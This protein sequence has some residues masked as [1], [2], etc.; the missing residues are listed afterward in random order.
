MHRCRKEWQAQQAIRAGNIERVVQVGSSH[1][2]KILWIS[3]G[4]PG[5]QRTYLL[6]SGSRPFLLDISSKKAQPVQVELQLSTRFVHRFVD[7]AGRVCIVE[8]LQYSDQEMTPLR[9]HTID[10]TTG[11]VSSQ[12]KHF[13]SGVRSLAAT[14]NPSRHWKL[15]MA[16]R[17]TIILIDAKTDTEVSR[18]VISP[19]HGALDEAEFVV[20]YLKLSQ[21]GAMLAA[22]LE[23]RRSTMSI[24]KQMYTGKGPPAVSEVHVY[25]TTTWQ[26]LL[27]IPLHA[28][29][30]VLK[31]SHMD[32]LIVDCH[33]ERADVCTHIGKCTALA[34]AQVTGNG[35]TRGTLRVLNPRKH[36]W[37]F[38][39]TPATS[40][41]WFSYD[42]SP[43]GEL[44]LQSAADLTRKTS[45]CIYDSHSMEL[46]CQCRAVCQW[47]LNG[48][49]S[50][51]APS[52][53]ATLPDGSMIKFKRG[54]GRWHATEHAAATAV[55]RA[56]YGHWQLLAQEM[57]SLGEAGVAVHPRAQP[58]IYAYLR[59]RTAFP[60]GL[61]RYEVELTDAKRRVLANWA[62]ADL[63]RQA[64]WS[65]CAATELYRPT[66]ADLPP[67][68][69]TPDGKGLAIRCGSRVL[70]M[71]FAEPS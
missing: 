35:T 69:W 62:L 71:H 60:A 27:S 66:R 39:E 14:Y 9:W 17:R 13:L 22:A 15:I 49:S 25:S 64:G 41:V 18:V 53:T 36:Q 3:G 42:W 67:L 58:N 56:A 63:A 26:C 52:L 6:T 28:V 51:R 57:L 24:L 37:A 65:P 43:G 47:A 4:A 23:N 38:V 5:L 2:E 59:R 10:G 70:I 7:R 19:K 32:L 21:S 68:E 11:Q 55:P 61:A 48:A 46:L 20:S 31:W 33:E 8:G 12:T 50:C 54:D 34:D 16:D 1:Q 45:C 29:Q 30:C 40:S 44:L